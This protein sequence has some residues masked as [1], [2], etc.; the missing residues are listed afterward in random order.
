[1]YARF[2]SPI[3]RP[4]G[5]CAV[6][7]MAFPL[8]LS[9]C[10]G[11][12]TPTNTPNAQPTTGSAAT[13]AAPTSAASSGVAAATNPAATTAGTSVS[14]TTAPAAPGATTAAAASAPLQNLTLPADSKRGAGG[15]LHLLW[16][17]APTILN[18]H[19]AQGTKDFDASRIVEEPLGTIGNYSSPIPD[20]PV[21]AKEIPSV[22]NGEV[23]ADGT[24]VTW[25]L[26]D[27][28]VWSDGQPF[29]ADDVIFTWKFVTDP[30]NGA[31]TITNYSQI[32]DI[33]AVDP[34]TVK[35]TFKAPTAVWYLPF[36]GSEGA[37]LPKHILETCT[38]VTQCPYNQKPIGTG[39]YVVTEFASGDH[40]N[41][42]ANDKFREPN[43]PYFA[44][45]EMKGGGDA[46]TAVKALIAGQTD[47]VWN[48]QVAPDILKQ[49]TD[50]GNVLGVIPGAS[51]E[52]IYI[53]FADPN[54]DVNGE[55]SSPQSK[56]PFW[57]D[58]NVRQA[59]ALAI[60]RDAMAKNLYGPA[61]ISTN[62]IVPTIWNG[63][64][65]QY[66]PK[67][68]NDLLDAAGWK[69]GSDGIRVKDGKQ[70]SIT[71]RTSVNDVRDKES[72]LIKNNLKAVGIAVDLRPVDSSV[73]FGQ[74]DNPDNLARF[75]TDLEM[76]TNG[77]SQPDMESYLETWT[78]DKIAQQSNGWKGTNVMRWNNPEYDKLVG[79]LTTVLDPAK[80]VE[81]FKQADTLI[82]GD[83]AQI[84][85]VART[86]L[87]AYAKGLTG[88]N[89]TDWDDDTWNIAHWTKK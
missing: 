59:L 39:P 32:Q 41:Y 45:V 6:F 60:D 15:T 29:T 26:K 33:V 30:K 37:V 71:F 62:T 76:Y 69:M 67:K 85:L 88:V 1:M 21:L 50:S 75:Q 55:K 24:S 5:L 82:T 14:S 61:G 89:I 52:K 17:Q 11:G 42:Q 27:G 43:A 58:K 22:Q 4:L 70:F 3:P 64:P 7:L 65:W 84:P 10:G 8:L 56:S 78:S 25:K 63:T 23:A 19:L 16:W 28:V 81:I 57:T 9:A 48:P 86:G 77:A 47:Y 12:S 68:A 46:A 74:P 80:R 83:Y 66:D 38:T 34:M 44:K 2:R 18:S 54:T 35:I 13:G 20:V 79:S 36:T 53:N 87:A 49:V 72:Q 31:T 40:V 73:F 51:S